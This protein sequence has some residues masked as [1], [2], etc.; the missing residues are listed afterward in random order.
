LPPIEQRATTF[1][2]TAL[3]SDSSGL[4]ISSNEV[5]Y[6]TSTTPLLTVFAL[7]DRILAGNNGAILVDVKGSEYQQSIDRLQTLSVLKG[8]QRGLFYPAAPAQRAEYAV[9]TLNGLNLRDLRDITQI[10]FVLGRKSTVNLAIQNAEGRSIVGL[11]RN[12]T[13]DAG[14]HTAVWNGRIDSGFVAPGRYTYVCTA[15]DARGEVT[16]LKGNLT[17][18]SQTPLNATGVPSFIDVKS[19]DWFARFLAVGEKQGLLKGFPDKTF[20]PKE[21]ISRVEATAIVVRAMGLEDL[22]KEWAGRKSG[23]LDSDNIAT[24]AMPYV[25]VATMEAKTSSGKPLMRGYPNNQFYQK[26]NCAAMKPL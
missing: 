21:P 1:K 13:L 22:T 20:R 5:E 3:I 15:K 18:V 9:M 2:S 24:W 8:R 7:P 17:I 4:A 19:S 16:S 14:E 6:S 25:N 11:I 26:A 23:F 12:T 10:K